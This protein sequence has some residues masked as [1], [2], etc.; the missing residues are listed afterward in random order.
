LRLPEFVAFVQ[1]LL[2]RTWAS[3]RKVHLVL[4]NLN[5]QFR[6]CFEEALGDS[7]ARALLRR[8]EFHHRP[9]HASGLNMAEIEIGILG[10]QCLARRWTDRAI[11]DVLDLMQRVY[12]ERIRIGMTSYLRTTAETWQGPACSSD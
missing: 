4:D 6:S 7:A 1:K 10:R 3:A 8:V 12:K 11:A 2:N 5:T 9:Q